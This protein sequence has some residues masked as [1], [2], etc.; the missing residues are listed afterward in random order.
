MSDTISR[1]ISSSRLKYKNQYAHLDGD[2]RYSA[3]I[4]EAILQKE[5]KR[6]LQNPW[7]LEG[8]EESN[9][10]VLT[11]NSSSIYSPT[12]IQ[13]D[14]VLAGKRKGG[15][16]SNNEIEKIVRRVHA[17]LWKRREEILPSRNAV[18]PLDL[19]NPITALN[20][21]GI[22]IKLHETL[23]QYNQNGSTFEVAGVIDHDSNSVSISR[24]FPKEIRNFT[25]AHELGHFVLHIA[26]GLHRDRPVDSAESSFREIAEYQAD[27][28]A[29]YFLMPAKQVRLI[30]ERLFLCKA[31]QLNDATAFALGF[32][33]LDDAARKLKTKADLAK[34][35]A[36]AE[37]FNGDRFESLSKHFSVSVS[38]MA[39]RLKELELI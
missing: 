18:N 25:A 1:L 26:T 21:F 15:A 12:H 10:S 31:F 32:G 24:R 14:T 30:F 2:G 7:A 4:D 11:E 33:S 34:F 5:R 36:S 3:I 13:V 28:F 27:K 22:E 8:T 9:H 20:Q 17:E 38:A 29:S 39:I 35:L 19:I 16:F 23:G 37:Y 6:I